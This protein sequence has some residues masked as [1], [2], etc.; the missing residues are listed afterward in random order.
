MFENINT[1]LNELIATRAHIEF[2]DHM[3]TF[4]TH[5]MRTACATH[6][7]TRMHIRA[8]A[9]THTLT[10]HTHTHKHTH[11]HTQTHTLTHTHA[12]SLAHTH[13]HTLTHTHTHTHCLS[14]T[15]HLMLLSAWYS[16]CPGCGLAK[17]HQLRVLFNR[18][19]YPCL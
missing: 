17:Q 3:K 11:S 6:T 18:S 15:L 12:R 14:H 1:G 13:A 2:D 7:Y 5:C 4:H 19:V 16:T 10:P 8:R 9:H